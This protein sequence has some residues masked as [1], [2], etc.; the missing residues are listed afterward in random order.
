MEFKVVFLGYSGSSGKTSLIERIIYNEFNEVYRTKNKGTYNIKSVQNYLGNEVI[1]NLWDISWVEAY[2]SI[3]KI[4]MK[5]S[6]CVILLYDITNRSSFYSIQEDFYP[7]AK[8]I[9]ENAPLFYL[10]ANKID[11]YKYQKV[12]YK[13]K[14]FFKKRKN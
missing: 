12:S 8:N 1:L 13:D 5:G 10:V 6:N 14:I 11:L 9:I 7:T 4:F 2:R 3:N